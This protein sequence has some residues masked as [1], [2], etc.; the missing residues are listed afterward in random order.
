MGCGRKIGM[1]IQFA[2]AARGGSEGRETELIFNACTPVDE[3]NADE[4]KNEERRQAR[5][6]RVYPLPVFGSVNCVSI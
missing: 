4:R 5:R 3:H 1:N 6:V 2:S